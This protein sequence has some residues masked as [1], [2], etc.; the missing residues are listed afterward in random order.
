MQTILSKNHISLTS[1]REVN[2]ICKPLL[3]LGINTFIYV[4]NYQNNQVIH[5]S[6]RL[7]WLRHYYQKSFYQIDPLMSKT[8]A[9]S[10]GFILWNT[11][12]GRDVYYD[13]DKYFNVS[14]G[15]VLAKNRHEHQN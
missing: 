13:A 11:L 1:T 8:D 15:I 2:R 7:E 9:C 10:P 4:K 14:H 6:N 12:N 5:L 3:N